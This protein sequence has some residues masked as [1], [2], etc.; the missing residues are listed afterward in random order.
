MIGLINVLLA[1]YDYVYL[2]LYKPN[3]TGRYASKWC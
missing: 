2:D 3:R 1:A